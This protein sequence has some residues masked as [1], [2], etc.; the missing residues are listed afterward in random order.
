MKLTTSTTDAINTTENLAIKI[1]ALPSEIKESSGIEQAEKPGIY[2]THSDANNPANIY[3]ID[4]KGNLL[5]TIT[6][7][8]AENIDWED[9][10]R[11]TKGNIYIGDTGNN[12]NKRKVLKIYKLNPQD[13]D[14]LQEITFEYADR[15][16]GTA[17][18]AHY[19]FDCE[20]IF[21]HQNKLHLVTKDREDGVQAK[22]YE[23]PDKPGTYEAK[24]IE[25]YEVNQPVTSADISPDGKTLMLLSKGKI[26]LFHPTATGGFFGGKMQTL[27]LGKVG[28][29]EGAV[30]TGNKELIITNEEGHLYRYS[31]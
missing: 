24:L 9:L 2:Y 5:A 23:L 16:N 19:E 11:D 7:N 6:L 12:S 28:Q 17:D 21:W 8:N 10:A 27:N 26:H 3:K 4:E 25:Q 13:Q 22:L 30:F 20:A 31:F 29:T 18:K 15:K 14:N 1:A